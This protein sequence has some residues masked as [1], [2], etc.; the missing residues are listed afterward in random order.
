MP[1][2]PALAHRLAAAD[3]RAVAAR[4]RARADRS[5]LS[6]ARA[7]EVPS[8]LRTA[9]AADS[10]ISAVR[11][12]RTP[13]STAAALDGPERVLPAARHGVRP[14]LAG[15]DRGL[16][17]GATSCSRATTR[18]SARYSSTWLAHSERYVAGNDRALRAGR[19]RACVVEVASNDGYLLQYVRAA[20]HSLSRRRADGEHRGCGREPRASTSSRSSSASRSA[21]ACGSEG[22][23]PTSWRPTTCLRTCPTSTISSAGFARLLKPAGVATFEFPHLLRLVAA[24]PVRHDLPRAFLVSCRSRP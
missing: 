24:E 15:A 1:L 14:V 2:D 12:R 3:R 23:L 9:D 4:R 18:T 19:A 17:A 11:R 22:K 16:R 5:R 10:S 7:C 8:L 13:T 20:R 6:R 21:R